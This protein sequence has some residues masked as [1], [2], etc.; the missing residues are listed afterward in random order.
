MPI[1][2]WD[3]HH[4]HPGTYNW[5][6]R[7]ALCDASGERVAIAVAGPPTRLNAVIMAAT[8]SMIELE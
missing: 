1:F 5:D 2:I 3:S 8:A 4:V 6:S 7:T